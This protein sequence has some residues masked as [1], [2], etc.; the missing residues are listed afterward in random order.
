MCAVWVITRGAEH[1]SAPALAGVKVVNGDVG[2]EHEEQED[3]QGIHTPRLAS[4][5]SIVSV[6]IAP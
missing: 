1:C 4:E 6:A 2:C 5:A 3:D